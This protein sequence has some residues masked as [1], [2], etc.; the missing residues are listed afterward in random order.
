MHAVPALSAGLARPTQQSG[1]AASLGSGSAGQFARL[2]ASADG[3]DRL[4]A[5]LS[6]Q[7]E[8]GDAVMAPPEPGAAPGTPAQ[9]GQR[10]PGPAQ[11]GPAQPGPVPT[12]PV[13][14]GRDQPGQP[15]SGLTAPRT[16]ADAALAVVPAAGTTG[17]AAAGPDQPAVAPGGT[18][19]SPRSPPPAR[20]ARDG[21]SSS[22]AAG[23]AARP[24]TATQAGAAPAES[25]PQAGPATQTS[26][27]ADAEVAASAPANAVPPPS[28]PLNEE[29]RS[30][31]AAPELATSATT[32]DPA[33]LAAARTGEATARTGAATAKRGAPRPADSSAERGPA[34]DTDRPD[35]QDAASAVPVAAPAPAFLP[36]PDPAAVPSPA[37]SASAAA[38]VDAGEAHGTA[39]AD[40][41]A[42][43]GARGH[44][45][46]SRLQGAPADADPS[47]GA[48]APPAP[49][50]HLPSAAPAQAASPGPSLTAQTP[51]H[52][53]AATAPA[54]PAPVPLAGGTAPAAAWAAPA[55]AE[56][57]V[58]QTAAALIQIAPAA[59]PDAPQSLTIHLSPADLGAV[60][61]RLER[62]QDGS[63]HVHV[64]AEH[65]TT[66]AL[67]QADR[68]Q[69]D[70]ALDQAGIPAEG[71]TLDFSLGGGEREAPR[72]D[73][74]RRQDTAAGPPDQV[75]AAPS[76]RHGLHRI[77]QRSTG[78]RAVLDITL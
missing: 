65:G 32:C 45:A 29:E 39:S 14:T 61:V 53:I 17:V 16:E 34:A 77:T 54:D 41:P 73:S 4:P 13:P 36:A 74:G 8:A 68:P 46:T 31:A 67:L 9:P 69:L 1:A 42:A 35:A 78:G 21:R 40:R 62:A 22:P 5:S 23:P 75:A 37:S 15:P 59:H 66:L 47:A 26:R 20:P 7:G 30:G 60:T 71:R 64:A 27:T 70:R 43:A 49:A 38:S 76:P 2:L 63:A 28:G 10:Q 25:A 58:R 19:T 33:G 57:P 50:P 24:G 48:A 56:P 72:D 52:V 55:L 12:G 44:A 18:A 6:Q 11:P 51:T 3:K